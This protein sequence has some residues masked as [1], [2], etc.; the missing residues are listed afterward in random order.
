MLERLYDRR[1][2][3]TVGH[4]SRWVAVSEKYRWGYKS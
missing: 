4:C 1:S 3:L 2:H